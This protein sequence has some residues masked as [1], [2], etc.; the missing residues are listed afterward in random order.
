MDDTDS[1]TTIVDEWE[2]GYITWRGLLYEGGDFETWL[3][4]VSDQ[5][6]ALM[7]HD[8]AINTAMQRTVR[9]CKDIETARLRS[10]V[11][12]L[13][14]Q[15]EVF[16]RAGLSDIQTPV[17]NPLVDA[18]QIASSQ[19]LAPGESTA[20]QT[21]HGEQ[22]FDEV[23]TTHIRFMCSHIYHALRVRIPDIAKG[24]IRTFLGVLDALVKPFPL[25]DLS[26]ET[27]NRIYGFALE[28]EHELAAPDPPLLSVNKQIR[29]ELK[30]M[31]YERTTF[32]HESLTSNS[33]ST[34]IALN[35]IAE[36]SQLIVRDRIRHLRKFQMAAVNWEAPIKFVLD[37]HVAR[38]EKLRK[39]MQLQGESIIMALL[40]CKD[41]WEPGVLRRR[42]CP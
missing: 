38:I 6:R 17:G 26:N 24:D 31:F 21:Q 25:L 35:E 37:E 39:P 7:R 41:L 5:E 18:R 34:E 32:I 19:S 33:A 22:T 11:K 12:D 8:P 9:H 2:P 36:W 42:S 15:L 14:A 3:R 16:S 27:R 28:P 20:D 10:Q 1:S 29:E 40:A 23:R 4:H 30:P 13:Q